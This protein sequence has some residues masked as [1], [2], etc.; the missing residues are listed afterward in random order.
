MPSKVR[1]WP[2]IPPPPRL[3]NSRIGHPAARDS[4]HLSLGIGRSRISDEVH[5]GDV[6]VAVGVEVAVLQI[7]VV[8]G[9]ELL[10]SI[11]LARA[12][13]DRFED[14]ARQ[15]LVVI[16]LETDW[17]RCSE[18]PGNGLPA[19]PEWSAPTSSIRPC[20]PGRCA[21][22]QASRIS[23]IDPFGDL[24]D[25]QPFTDGLDV[26]QRPAHERRRRLVDQLSNSNR[27]S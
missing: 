11:R 17:S 25:E 26:G 6:L 27:P 18:F 22:A 21:P 16:D 20:V 12:L 13:Q 10:N 24:L 5:Q 2:M 3:L 14:L 19:Q 7:D 23:G 15:S 9:G 4:R 8:L 1:T